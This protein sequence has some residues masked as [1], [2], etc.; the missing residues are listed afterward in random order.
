MAIVTQETILF[1][2]TIWNNLCYGRPEM[3]ES[4]VISAAQ[5]A[6][7]HDFISDLPQGYQTIIGDR[8]QRLSGGQR[9]RLAIARALLLDPA[10]LLLDDP[11]AAVDPETEKEILEAIENAMRGRTTFMVANRISS[12]RRADRI[13]VMEDGR[14]VQVGT[15][16]ELVRVDGPYR[17]TAELQFATS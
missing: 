6:L 14:I 9:Q 8:G 3:P 16:E 10:I 2:D 12:L 7:A 5:A 13:I 15:H 11:T 1:N 4:K 17:R